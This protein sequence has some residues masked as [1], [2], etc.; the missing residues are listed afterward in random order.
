[1]KKKIFFFIILFFAFSKIVIAQPNLSPTPEPGTLGGKCK[2]IDLSALDSSIPKFSTPDDT[3]PN[4]WGCGNI[5]IAKFCVSDLFN[6]A[7]KSANEFLHTDELLKELGD[8]GACEPGLEPSTIDIDSEDCICID[9]NMR[10]VIKISDWFC[11]KYIQ[12]SAQEKIKSSEFANCSSC[13]SN[14]GYYSGIGCIYFSDWKTF[15][16]KNI[17]GTLVGLAGFIALICIVYSAF[18]LQLSQGN[19][20][21]IKKAQELLTSCI[22]GLMLIIFSVFILKLIGVDI[23]R[24]PGFGK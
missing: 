22:M 21:K 12:G 11:N 2:N 17:F 14:G 5:L 13:F 9:P 20:E 4:K 8:L 15:F 6:S 1:M 24:I 16:E 23:L 7:K 10:G 18:Q 3:D 19:T